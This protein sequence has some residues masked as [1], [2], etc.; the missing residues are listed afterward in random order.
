MF[1]YLSIVF[2]APTSS[3]G[4]YRFTPV[5]QSVHWFFF[6]CV[7][8]NFKS[9]IARGMIFYK[10]NDRH[11]NLL[12]CIFSCSSF[13]CRQSYSPFSAKKWHLWT[14][15]LSW[16]ADSVTLFMFRVAIDILFLP[17]MFVCLFDNFNIGLKFWTLSDRAF[18][19]GIVTLTFTCDLL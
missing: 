12:T 14:C 8:R 1:F 5:C 19:F 17:C 3:G 10:L 9:I 6:L 15:V 13:R 7:E 4:T 18:I 16:L 2:Y 11:V